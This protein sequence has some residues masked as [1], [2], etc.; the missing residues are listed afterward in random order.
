MDLKDIGREEICRKED[1]RKG[2][3]RLKGEKIL[4]KVGGGRKVA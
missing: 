2:R 1:I 4:I 3:D